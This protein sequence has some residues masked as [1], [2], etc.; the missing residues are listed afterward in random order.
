MAVAAAEHPVHGRFLVSAPQQPRVRRAGDVTRIVIGA[1]LLLWAVANQQRLGPVNRA[2]AGLVD[3]LP[4]WSR[5]PL[6][7]VYS[8]AFLYGL[9]LLVV[10]LR[11]GRAHRD[12]LRDVLLASLVAAVLGVILVR[13]C[14]GVWPYVVPEL[15]LERPQRQTPVFRIALTTALLL[16]ASPH[17]VV[18]LRRVGWTIVGLSAVAGAGLGFGL[19][20]DALG[21]VGVGMMA[22]GTTFLLFGA[23]TGLPHLD[24]VARGLEQLATPLTDLTVP[25]TR[26]W[27]V[28]PVLGRTSDG[29]PVLVKVYGRDATDQQLLAKL[30][31]TLWYRE[32]RRSFTFSRL[33]S[34]EREALLTIWA[35]RAGVA[36]PRVLTAGAPDAELALLVVTTGGRRLDRSRPEEVPDELLDHLWRNLSTL[37]AAGMAHGALTTA[38]IRVDD[39]DDLRIEDWSAATLSATAGE[40]ARDVVSLL[41]TTAAL[42]GVERAVAAATRGLGPDPLRGALPYLQLPAMT[43][44]TRGL[45]AAPKA[46]VAELTEAL[47]TTLD[48]AAPEPVELRRIPPRTLLYTALGTLAAMSLIPALAGIDL[49]AVA[50]QLGAA[51]WTLLLLAWVIGQ[52][53]FVTEATSMSFATP[54]MLPFRPLIILQVAAKLIGIATPGVTGQI[55]ANATFL[56]RFGVAPAASLT[57]GTMDAVAGVVVEVIV[58]TVAFTFSDLD[59]GVDITGTELALGR[60]TVLLGV[61]VVAGAVVVLRL[62]RPRAWVRGVVATMWEAVRAVVGEPNR[63]LGL[64]GGN[65]ATRVVRAL[66]LWLVLRSL[67]EGLGLGVALVVVIATGLLQA[68]V[69]VPGGIGVAE[70]VMTGFLVVLGV[71]EAAAFAATVTYRGIVFYLPILQGGVALR[72][73]T[74]HGFL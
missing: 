72:W 70:A 67:G 19:P 41:F 7:I 26:S 63:A 5:D 11:G 34:V 56:S 17:L 45:A 30:W 1:L 55:A 39:D 68:V 54:A 49:A 58:L 47:V 33:Q 71:E 65:L 42:V 12:A 46:L 25:P 40:R 10:L 6:S 27:G 61:A 57:Q 4:A 52:A 69:P 36:V 44:D 59:L 3:V 37:H 62:P 22:A 8:F 66:V 35:E 15:G 31:R 60:L 18:P 28:R 73:L 43:T 13:V 9:L 50:N 16:A 2:F 48:T 53:V 74:R 20:S 23:P 51:T 32:Q 21:A 14:N 64:L 24:A 29:Q 38:R